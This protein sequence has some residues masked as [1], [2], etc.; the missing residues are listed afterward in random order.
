[1]NSVGAPTVG[2]PEIGAEDLAGIEAAVR[3]YF[4][5]WFEGDAERMRR[6]LHPGLAKRTLIRDEDGA[7]ALGESPAAAMIDATGRGA[8]RT[9]GEGDRGIEMQVVDAYGGIASVVVRSTV[10]REYLH[11][12]LTRDGW[13]IVNALWR[14]T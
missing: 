9:R 5:G 7:E 13:K 1:M 3:D 6:A 10:Y 12:A 2:Q 11:L 8:G 4:G 14:W